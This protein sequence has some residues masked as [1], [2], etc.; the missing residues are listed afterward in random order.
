MKKV[1]VFTEGF[2]Q[3]SAS[4]WHGDDVPDDGGAELMET[5]G[6]TLYLWGNFVKLVRVVVFCVG[7][8]EISCGSWCPFSVSP[9]FLVCKIEDKG[10]W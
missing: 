1:G 6:V 8:L 4:K 7:S 2:E 3:D 9:G 10:Q 5:K